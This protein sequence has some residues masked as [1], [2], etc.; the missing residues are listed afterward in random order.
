MLIKRD[1]RSVWHPYTQM[2][3]AD[4]PIAIVRGKGALLYDE[5]G[6]KYIDAVSSWWVNIHGHC[7]PYIAAAIA[8][9]AKQLEH[10]IF[11]GFTHESAIALAEQLLEVLPSHFARVF[12][13]D[14]GSTAVEVA[15]KM[16][17]QYWSNRG[18][19]KTTIVAF[20]DAYHGDTFGSMSISGEGAF[21]APFV[22]LLFDIIRIPPPFKGDEK[23]SLA[24]LTKALRGNDVAAFIFEPLVMGVAGMRMYDAAALNT[25]ITLCKEKNVLT[26]ADEVFTGFG[27]TGKVFAC[28]YLK[29]KPDIIC[30]SKGITGGFLPLGVTVCT[31]EV[32]R[33]FLSDDKLKTFFHGHS[34]TANPLACAASLASMKILRSK[35]CQS[36]IRRI[37]K[38]HEAMAEKLRGHHA[39]KDVR[40]TGTILAV[41]LQTSSDTSYF[42]NVRDSAYRFFL[43]KGIVMRPLGNVIYF[44]P[45]YCITDTQMT[46]VYSAMEEFMRKV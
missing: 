18:R 45:P 5:H 36:R 6:K 16:A 46:T 26:I 28:E 2:Q 1:K 43:K 12:Y 9:Q 37:H 25:L 21:T 10:V 4:P 22:P 41:E 33:A 32:Y 3:T 14:D 35:D 24:A 31:N 7:N 34:Y 13:S 38:R 23:R 17:V 19:R 11:A 15:L 27:R 29:Q 39:I 8:K 40:V 42:N 44:L 30:L 20:E